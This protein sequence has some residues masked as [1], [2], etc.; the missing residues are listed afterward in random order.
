MRTYKHMRKIFRASTLT[1]EDGAIWVALSNCHLIFDY[2]AICPHCG[3]EQLM[4]FEQIKW[5]A[6]V[7]DPMVIEATRDVWYECI[8]CKGKWDDGQRKKAVQAGQRRDR[9]KKRLVHEAMEAI[10][11]L[12]IGLPAP[13]PGTTMRT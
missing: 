4:A 10:R 13:A 7:R 9:K 12:R 5:T 3:H 1:V 2:Y 8:H 6:G 11:P